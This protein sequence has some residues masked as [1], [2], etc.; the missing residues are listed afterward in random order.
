[1]RM[2]RIQ[3][4]HIVFGVAALLFVQGTAFAEVND[5]DVD[6][7]GLAERLYA[8]GH[9]LRAE[10]AL[11][12]VNV[13]E[14]ESDKRAFH[15][16]SG[17]IALQRKSYAVAVTSLT[18][19]I[20]QGE[21]R[22]LAH[23]GLAQAHFH[24]KSFQS[25]LNALR[26]A[27]PTYG[28][29]SAGYLMAAQCYWSL[30]Q[31]DRAL[32]V[33]DRAHDTFPTDVEPRRQSVLYLVEL[34]LYHEALVASD[35]LMRHDA[36]ALDDFIAVAHALRSAR[37]P[38]QVIALLEQARVYRPNN[39]KLKLLLAHA[40][41][42]A[43][44]PY[45]AGLLFES[46]ALKHPEYSFEAAHAF[47]LAK[48]YVRALSQNARVPNSE[49]RFKQR[50]SILLEDKRFFEVSAMEKTLA[51]LGLLD[52]DEIR[53]AMAYAHFQS[54]AGKKAKRHLNQIVDIR[55]L[56]QVSALRRSIATCEE[57]GWKCL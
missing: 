40:Y 57:S 52:D 17:L 37:Q 13:D 25:A 29:I 4:P 8:D 39:R 32:A 49:K 45:S 26:R 22:A 41:H 18:K 7:V 12:R 44:K 33:L 9:L 28:G 15:L 20:E 42:D 53:Y 5:D 3:I 11:R 36:V 55:L 35:K 23:L 54:A 47:K 6:Y 34:G 50:L 14:R 1:M 16:I 43:N 46:L 38:L 19:A 31:H 30:R 48:R 51:T 27:K 56:E 21:S 24:Q 10:Q 2:F